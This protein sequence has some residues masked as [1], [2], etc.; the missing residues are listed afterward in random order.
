MAKSKGNAHFPRAGRRD[1]AS[2]CAQILG[3][4]P[5]K[6]KR[7]L[8][9]EAE[10]RSE[11]DLPGEFFALGLQHGIGAKRSPRGRAKGPPRLNIALGTPA[12]ILLLA[13]TR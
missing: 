8:L 4:P 10:C 12:P 7:F 11:T 13:S 1:A 3:W 6:R 9:R 2:G 5:G